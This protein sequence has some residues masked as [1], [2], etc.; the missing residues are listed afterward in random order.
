[1]RIL[2]DES[3]PHE[4]RNEIPGHAVSTVTESGWSSLKNGELLNRAAGKFDVFV[5]ADQNLQFQQNLKKLPIAVLILRDR[6][7]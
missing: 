1:M 7:A 5:T 2:L 3:L 4:L 6:R